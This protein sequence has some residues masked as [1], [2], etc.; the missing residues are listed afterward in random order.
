M[1]FCEGLKQKVISIF[2]FCSV[3]LKLILVEFWKVCNALL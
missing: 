1:Y 3:I 2:E